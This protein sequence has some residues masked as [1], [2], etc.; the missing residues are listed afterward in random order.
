MD[1]IGICR[2]PG[3]RSGMGI[4]AQLCS[5]E[6]TK[7]MRFNIGNFFSILFI[8][9]SSSIDCDLLYSKL[10]IFKTSIR[11]W[12]K[13]CWWIRFAPLN[14]GWRRVET[15]W[16]RIVCNKAQP[17]SIIIHGENSFNYI[18]SPFVYVYPVD[19]YCMPLEIISVF[20]TERV[21][22]VDICEIYGNAYSDIL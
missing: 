17:L 14:K 5:C 1:T 11:E 2:K 7:R 18:E 22:N 16:K 6:D 21:E 12:I 20:Q 13:T 4:D 10:E 8:Y 9:I 3:V 15:L 19:V